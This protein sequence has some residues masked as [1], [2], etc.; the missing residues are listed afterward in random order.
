MLASIQTPVWRDRHVLPM[1]RRMAR[2]NPSAGGARHNALLS[3]L[4]Y[5]ILSF[6]QNQML[7]FFARLRVALNHG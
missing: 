3:H 2:S 7:Q 4:L 1:A 5:D 6:S